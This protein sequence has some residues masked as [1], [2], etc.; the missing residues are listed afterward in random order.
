MITQVTSSLYDQ[1]IADFEARYGLDTSTEPAELLELR[2]QAFGE[3]RSLGFPSTKVED[4]KYVNLTPFL[5]EP[6][7]TDNEDA[8]L[9]DAGLLKAACIPSLDCYK[10]VLVN[11]RYAAD[12]SDT[13]P[14]GDVILCSINEAFGKASFKKYFGKY[15]STRHQHFAAMNTALFRDGLFIEVK[16]KAVVD[17]PIHVIH[18]SYVSG[19]L[20]TQPRHLFVV[21]ALAA[22][23]IIESYITLEGAGDV[24]VNNVSEII[25]GENAHLQH[26]YIQTGDVRTRYIHTTEVHQEANS[27][28]NNYKASFPGTG[29]LRNN[30][31]VVLNGENIESHLYGLYLSGGKQLVD[32]H[33]LV[34]HRKPH[35][36]SNELYKGVMK[37]ESIG[38]FNG[39]IYVREKAQK[40]N[41]FQQNNNLML[42]R[43]AV[44]DSK[45]QLEIYADDVKCS[46]GST[47]GQ[48]N[49]QALFYLKSRGIG[50][51]KARA[52]LV[53]AFAF[54]VTE[55]IPLAE[56]QGH[57]NQ[58]IEEGLK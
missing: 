31:N 33:T 9:A 26:Y 22:A 43:K 24:F 36:Q 30:L 50:E 20:F 7:E 15:L 35:C 28:Y 16:N 54:D 39:K 14:G 37:D 52:L 17:K 8:F 21:G 53:H 41:A 44:V 57:I 42:G 27:L 55:K 5:K 32:N 49:D 19:H 11:G 23:T 2:R 58:L 13:I 51:E 4:W 3:F 56:V 12:L 6:F 45:P 38:V 10:I 1:L 18:A 25:V 40:T 46:H 48:F 29:L 34:D 47:I